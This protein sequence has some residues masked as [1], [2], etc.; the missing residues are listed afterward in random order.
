MKMHRWTSGCTGGRKVWRRVGLTWKAPSGDPGGLLS[1]LLAGQVVWPGFDQHFSFC[2]PRLLCLRLP[3]PCIRRL[4]L[5]SQVQFFVTPWTAACQAS[6]F[7]I[8]Q[9]LLKVRSIESLMIS[10]HLILCHPLCHRPPPAF[11]LS[12]HRS[13]FQGVRSSHQVAKVLEVKLQHQSLMNI[14]PWFPLGLTG[15]D[16]LAVQGTLK[17]LLQHDNSKASIL[18]H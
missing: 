10:N 6:L 9:S 7:S 15:L 2:S 1:L 12:Q 3:H 18:Q 14:Q 4:F 13:L 11:N 5:F 16:F 8:S 17:S